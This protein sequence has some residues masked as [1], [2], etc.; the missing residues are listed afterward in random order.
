M[1]KSGMMCAALAALFFAGPADAELK[2]KKLT[3]RLPEP[4][5]HVYRVEYESIE[6][7]GGVEKQVRSVARSRIETR[8][9]DAGY[10]QEWRDSL[11]S[12]EFTGYD[13]EQKKMLGDIFK[14]AE[15]LPVK[16][17][18]TKD[19]AFESVQNVAEWAALFKA[20]IDKMFSVVQAD[21]LSKIP[22][23][24]RA[25]AKEQM[26]K[27]T[28]GLMAV[29]ASP[30]YVQKQLEKT[31]FAYSFFNGG[32]LDPEQAYEMEGSTANPFGGEPFPLKLH[33]EISLDEKD[34]GFVYALYKTRLDQDKGR[35]ALSAAIKQIVGKDA[36]GVDA[37]IEKLLKE[38]EIST[39]VNSR[40]SLQT[41]VVQWME[42]V[43]TKQFPGSVEVTTTEMTLED[44]A[45]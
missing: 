43:E 29:M 7:K 5:T 34:P 2:S 21:A 38:F 22:V 32:G 9:T 10:I 42:Y 45:K 40:I 14:A 4:T 17:S 19:G 25:A 18:L 33:I 8:K 35:P 13:D 16:V 23:D 24:R 20:E 37:E 3:W 36:A 15:N 11:V 28:S 1:M 30:A 6:V 41:G 31:P 39:E 12:L 26:E 27:Q 44:A